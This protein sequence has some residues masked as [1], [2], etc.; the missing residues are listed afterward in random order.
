[1]PCRCLVITLLVIVLLGG[2]RSPREAIG[3]SF[4]VSPWTNTIM[5]D[6]GRG[7]DLAIG[8]EAPA[9][10]IA[11]HAGL[12]WIVPRSYSTQTVLVLAGPIG[13]WPVGREK[14]SVFISPMVGYAYEYWERDF[15]QQSKAL[16]LHLESG[17]KLRLSRHLKW[18]PSIGVTWFESGFLAPDED[19]SFEIRPISLEID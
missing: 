8:L 9:R 10:R 1:M 15:S 2:F 4:Y 19:P 14:T 12:R 11:F 18:R 7:L 16:L 3:A 5:D 17:V 13:S 6:N